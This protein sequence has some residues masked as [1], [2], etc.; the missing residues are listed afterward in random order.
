[1]LLH[2]A[3]NL[4]FHTSFF[5]SPKNVLLNMLSLTS[6]ACTFIRF[7]YMVGLGKMGERNRLDGPPWYQFALGIHRTRSYL[8]EGLQGTSVS[9]LLTFSAT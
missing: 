9:H 7:I 8:A 4:P 3:V 6:L 1:M 5:S 2:Q